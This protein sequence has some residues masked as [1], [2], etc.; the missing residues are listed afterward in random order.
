MSNSSVH[1]PCAAACSAVLWNSSCSPGAFACSCYRA[2]PPIVGCHLAG[3]GCG[4]TRSC[5]LEANARFQFETGWW[6]RGQWANAP[7]RAHA[8]GRRAWSNLQHAK[9]ACSGRLSE[10]TTSCSLWSSVMRALADFDPM[11]EE[12]V[13]VACGR[14]QTSRHLEISTHCGKKLCASPV[15]VHNTCNFEPCQCNINTSLN[16]RLLPW[17]F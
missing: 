15:A 9:A 5:V 1:R 3:R 13:N 12:I 4:R 17:S 6:R 7:C 11:W 2:D 10:C 8:D 16:H 14:W